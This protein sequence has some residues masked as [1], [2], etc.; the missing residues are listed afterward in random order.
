M[1]STGV[2]FVVILIDAGEGGGSVQ[3]RD[4]RLELFGERRTLSCQQVQRLVEV[5]EN[6]LLG[7]LINGVDRAHDCAHGLQRESLQL[8]EVFFE[9]LRL[10][11]S[12]LVLLA[13]DVLAGLGASHLVLGEVV[14]H[15]QLLVGDPVLHQSHLFQRKELH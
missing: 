14:E 5:L 12:L 9:S 10:E 7:V 11:D 15:R 4:Q 8:S 2:T 6:N 3:L 13:S 1:V